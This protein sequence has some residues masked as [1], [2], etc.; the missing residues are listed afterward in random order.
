MHG[1]W[2]FNFGRRR[3]R[4]ETN[5]RPIIRPELT[6]S[7]AHAFVID[8]KRYPFAVIG[9]LCYKGKQIA[10]QMEMP[11]LQLT[12]PEDPVTENGGTCNRL[13]WPCTINDS[14]AVEAH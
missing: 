7:S 5:G 4:L 2:I 6:D 1:S 12:G 3:T 14:S 9:R 10:D 11:V 13:R 8:D